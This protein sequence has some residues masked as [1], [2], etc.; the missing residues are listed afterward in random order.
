MN[1]NPV[2]RAH[3]AIKNVRCTITELLDGC[4]SHAFTPPNH[5]AL[6]NDDTKRAYYHG[7]LPGDRVTI[8]VGD[9]APTTDD[10]PIAYGHV[11]SARHGCDWSCE[12]L[13]RL[14]TVTIEGILL[15]PHNGPLQP[16]V[17]ERYRLDQV[18]HAD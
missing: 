14:I 11:T 10:T 5:P 4:P 13:C 6:Q 16:P 12:I 9:D 2:A 1:D 7:Y 8:C 3:A 18:K 15:P 17:T